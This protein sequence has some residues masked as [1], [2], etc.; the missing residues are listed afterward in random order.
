MILFSTR[1]ALVNSAIS[2]FR[3]SIINSGKILSSFIFDIMLPLVLRQKPTKDSEE[4]HKKLEKVFFPFF[5]MMNVAVVVDFHGFSSLVFEVRGWG[6][7]RAGN[8]L[9]FILLF[10]HLFKYLFIFLNSCI[11]KQQQTPRSN[12]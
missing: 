12:K 10:A 2:K 1:V 5:F 9:F 6:L 11:K 3:S 8:L 7:L 4:K